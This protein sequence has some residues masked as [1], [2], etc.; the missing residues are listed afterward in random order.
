[1]DELCVTTINANAGSVIPVTTTAGPTAITVADLA[2]LFYD[3]IDPALLATQG[4]ALVVSRAV[5]KYLRTLVNTAGYPLIQNADVTMVVENDA[6]YGGNQTLSYKAPV[7]WGV[8]VVTSR[9]MSSSVTSL[10][11]TAILGNFNQGFIVRWP[12]DGTSVLR[13]QER[14]ADYGQTG[15][16]TFF[17]A[18][19]KIRDPLAMALLAQHA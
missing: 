15:M 2:S 19:A 13:L 3:N 11:Q 16:V 14:Y 1:M 8:P 9:S 12:K 4:S 6:E 5:L 7:L 10:S 18:D 17:R